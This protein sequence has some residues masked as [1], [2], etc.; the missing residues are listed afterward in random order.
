MRKTNSS[1]SMFLRDSTVFDSN[2]RMVTVHGTHS[3]VIERVAGVE[4]FGHAFYLEDGSEI[5]NRFAWNLAAFA[6]SGFTNDATSGYKHNPRNVSGIFSHPG[7]S[8]FSYP[9][10]SAYNTVLG[11]AVA[12]GWL[13]DYLTPTLFWIRN[14]YNVFIGKRVKK[15]KI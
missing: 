15:K 3:T 4:C 6:K 8:V 14:A 5:L 9:F 1:N 7:Q 10:G 12:R 11:D 13:S 2:T